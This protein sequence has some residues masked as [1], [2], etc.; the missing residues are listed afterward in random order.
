[1]SDAE[2]LDIINTAISDLLSKGAS[3]YSIAGRSVTYQDLGMLM[4][5]R[6]R[7]QSKVNRAAAGGMFRVAKFQRPR[8]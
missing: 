1:M 6:D 4:E 3:S 2:L 8:S 5:Q 7:L